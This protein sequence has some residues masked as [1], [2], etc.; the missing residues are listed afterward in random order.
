MRWDD[1]R[2]S[3]NVED[4][5][6]DAG[7]RRMAAA[8]VFGLPI[9]GGGLGIGTI[10]VLGLIGW[11]LGID[12]QHAD[13]RRR[14]DQPHLAQQSSSRRRRRRPAQAGAPSRRDGP[15]SSP[16][17]SA[18]PRTLE[19][20]LLQGN[21]QNYRAPRAACST[22][23]V[24]AR[25]ACGVAQ[26]AMGP[27]YCPAD[28]QH[29]SRHLVLPR[30]R[31]A[32]SRLRCRQQVLPVRAGLCDR[33][34][35]RP[36]RAESARHPA[37]VAAGCKRAAGSQ[38]QANDIQ[39]RVELQADCLAGV[40]ANHENAASAGRASPLHRAGRHRGGVAHRGGDRRRHAAEAR[41][42]L[43]GAGL[44]H[45]RHVR[46]APALVHVR[47]QSGQVSSCNTFASKQL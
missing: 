25:S 28:Q 19:R 34:R 42:G 35:G 18:A 13:R 29:L 41:A 1:F 2:R 26:S 40:W 38:A 43:R 39:V 31:D 24:P 33:A 17:C 46:A 16:P 12:P 9:G 11:A 8:A 27:F 14:D 37:E 4:R 7:W 21:G 30:H 23:A 36:S 22:A 10:I 44:L 6:G 15:T 3:D 32:A 45:P 5:R 47:V 20:H